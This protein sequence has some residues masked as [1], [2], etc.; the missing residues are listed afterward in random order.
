MIEIVGILH[1][2]ERERLALRSLNSISRMSWP[3]IARLPQY[4]P[5][6]MTSL[7]MWAM[8]KR[9]LSD[10]WKI[11]LRIP[12]EIPTPVCSVHGV[13]H[14]YDCAVETVKAKAKQRPPR[15]QFGWLMSFY[16]TKEWAEI[17]HE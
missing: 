7:Y 2:C 6:P 15:H 8:G 16:E 1:K 11:K 10:E 14:C 4:Y 12:V 9:D 17:I 5:I 3:K 13:V